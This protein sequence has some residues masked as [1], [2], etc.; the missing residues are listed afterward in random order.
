MLYTSETAGPPPDPGGE[1]RRTIAGR[2]DRTRPAMPIKGDHLPQS[3]TLLA[4]RRGAEQGHGAIGT[5]REG[6]HQ[7]PGGVDS[8]LPHHPLLLLTPSAEDGRPR[9]IDDDVRS[10]HRLLSLPLLG[11][12]ALQIRN[13]LDSSCSSWRAAGEQHNLV[14]LP[15]QTRADGPT[16]KPGSSCHQDV[17]PFSPHIRHQAW[18]PGSPGLSYSFSP[19]SGST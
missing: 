19:I 18:C 10:R 11:G 6:L 16:D 3:P 9:Q 2:I 1:S 12:I 17:H 5:E 7:I 15:D 4:H 13:S 8:A 14:P